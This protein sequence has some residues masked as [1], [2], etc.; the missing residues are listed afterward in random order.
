MPN[1]LDSAEEVLNRKTSRRGFLGINAQPLP[2]NVGLNFHPRY[3]GDIASEGIEQVTSGSTGLTGA[4]MKRLY[5]ADYTSVQ[6]SVLGTKID[7]IGQK[8]PLREAIA[9][10]SLAGN[11][12]MLGSLKTEFGGMMRNGSGMFSPRMGTRFMWNVNKTA[13]KM[14][15]AAA[16]AAVKTANVASKAVLGAS[17]GQVGAA[18]G[19]VAGLGYMAGSA[20]GISGQ[21]VVNTAGAVQESLRQMNKPRYGRSE[22]G[23]STQGLLFGLNNSRRG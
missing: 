21:Q 7:F 10:A 1:I 13:I 2:R 18:A 11:Q 23:Q 9:G 20:L 5:Q 8:V 15:M 17:L 16:G 3:F 12:E 19:I 22:L 6:E 14:N 4:M